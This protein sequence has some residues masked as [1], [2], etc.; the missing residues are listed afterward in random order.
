[1]EEKKYWVWLTMVFGAGSSRL[2]KILERYETAEDAYLAI[3]SGE[4][5]SF[6]T[7]NERRAVSTPLEAAENLLMECEKRG[8]MTVS[9]ESEDYPPQLRHITDPPAILYYKG[10]IRCLKGTKTITAIGSRNSAEYPLRVANRVCYELARRGVVII[11]GFALGVDITSQMAAASKGYPTVAVL[12]CGIDVDYPRENYRC[13]DTIIKAGGALVTEFPLGTKALPQNFPKR[14]RILSA[15]S[16][17][18]VVFQASKKSGSLI[19]ASLAADQG[20]DVFCLPPADIYS[21]AYSG[22]VMLLSEGASPFFSSDDIYS[23]FG[24][25]MPLY[26][27]TVDDP[28]EDSLPQ[29]KTLQK[30]TIPQ[31]VTEEKTADISQQK[32]EIILDGIQADIARI[33]SDGPL[34]AD[35]L[36]QKLGIDMSELMIELTEMEI[37]GAVRSLPG[38][39]YEKF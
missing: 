30:E 35:V 4:C 8:V 39:I 10:D 26:V 21:S 14:N 13:R 28:F 1:M 29:E 25:G 17:A 22:N 2:W 11:S 36:A 6:L 12:G 38:K 15:L 24:Y 16:K 19:T 33:L 20:R 3:T 32:D 7:P 34:H 23:C 18:T 31:N 5:E 27:E 9:Y 37:L